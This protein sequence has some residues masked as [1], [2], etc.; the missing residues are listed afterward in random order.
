MIYLQQ[1]VRKVNK[2]IE[3][4]SKKDSMDVMVVKR[5]HL[6]TRGGRGTPLEADLVVEETPL[7]DENRS[8]N[9]IAGRK[10]LQLLGKS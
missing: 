4:R 7:E 8:K 3:V 6:E 1:R 2:F 5:R 10:I 9:R